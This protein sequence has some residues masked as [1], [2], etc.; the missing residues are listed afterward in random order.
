MTNTGSTT[1]TAPTAGAEVI[2]AMRSIQTEGDRWRLAEALHA[3][4]PSGLEGFADIIDAATTAGVLGK[5]SFNTLR[6]YRDTAARWP[7]DLRVPNVSFSA[8]RTAMTIDIKAASKLLHA[9]ARQKGAGGVTVDEVRR[10]IAV[11]QG[12][13]ITATSAADKATAA[14]KIEIVADIKAGAPQ[15][16]ASIGPDTGP[17]DLDKLHAGLTKAIAHVERLR[18][19]AARKAAS[20]SKATKSVATSS[21]TARKAAA[22]TTKT[23]ARRRGDLRGL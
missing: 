21:A 22:S 10:A 6:L 9:L 2:E 3:Q 23:S 18:A 4:I 7:A 15:L 5:L 14:A 20:A 12:K 1:I 19:K 8:H 11:Q 17:D 16:I 13:P